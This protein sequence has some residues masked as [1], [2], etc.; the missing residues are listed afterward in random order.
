MWYVT[1]LALFPIC[2]ADRS[3]SCV[4]WL[5]DGVRAWS[6]GDRRTIVGSPGTGDIDFTSPQ[7]FFSF[8]RWFCCCSFTCYFLFLLHINF[9]YSCSIP[10]MQSP[11]LA[12][13]HVCSISVYILTGI[14]C[15]RTPAVLSTPVPS[16][17]PGS[18]WKERGNFSFHFIK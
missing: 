15:F 3:T 13:S 5:K 10:F 9:R 18:F 17:L 6:S 12:A 16:R 11:L 14:C 4:G 7:W 8:S 2:R 1:S